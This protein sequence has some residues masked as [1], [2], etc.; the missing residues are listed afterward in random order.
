[1]RPGNPSC[2]RPAARLRRRPVQLLDGA[3]RDV[4]ADRVV[5]AG[6]GL[7][8]ERQR[9]R[10]VETELREAFRPNGLVWA[11]VDLSPSVSIEG[12]YQYDWNE[13]VIDPPG[14]I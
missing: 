10:S 1:M 13:T 6:A 5:P 9:W 14:V 12:F 3:G 7:E 8:R 2:C 11:S 4:D